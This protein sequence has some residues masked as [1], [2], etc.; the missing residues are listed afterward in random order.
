M[1]TLGNQ[2]FNWDALCQ[3]QELIRW[4]SVVE[5]NFKVNKIAKKL[6]EGIAGTDSNDIFLYTSGNINNHPSI[7]Q[8]ENVCQKTKARHTS[9]A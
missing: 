9:P 8:V 6:S 2:I 7:V 5:G 4:K 3:E 1:L